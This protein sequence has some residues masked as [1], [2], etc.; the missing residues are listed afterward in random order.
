[1]GNKSPISGL[2]I[3]RALAEI[4]GLTACIATMGFFKLIGENLFLLPAFGT[5]ANKRLQVL[6]T[7]ET[8]T[9]LRCGHNLLLRPEP[10]S[11]VAGYRGTRP[12]FYRQPGLFDPGILA[13]ARAI[14]GIAAVIQEFA[15]FFAR[16]ALFRWC[17]GFQLISTIAA[18]PIGHGNHLLYPRGSQAD[19]Q[20]P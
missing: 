20:C 13:A 14:R 3:Q 9:V 5:G 19:F 17:V 6:M 8:W 12:T 7:F 2:S 10:G 4:D 11:A 15:F 18:F 16:R 1:M